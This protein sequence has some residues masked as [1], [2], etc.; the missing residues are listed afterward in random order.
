MLDQR[1]QTLL[2]TLIERYIADGHPVGSRALSKYSNLELSP[3]TIR[4]V[5]SDLEEMG[6]I[7]SP[8][9][10]AGRVPTP[11][12]Y[13]FF[14]D[15]L[16]TVQPLGEAA[17]SAV[18][19]RIRRDV[20]QRAIST[21]AQVLSNLSQFAGVVLTPRR[22][23]AF[24]HVEFMRLSDSRVLLII[25]TPDGDV[26]NRILFSDVP[27]TSAQLIEAANHLNAEFAGLGF[28]DILAK[29]RGEVDQIQDD[30]TRLM[31]AAVEAS[32]EALSEDAEDVVI[33]GERNLLENV[34]L[35][36]NM[37]NLR[38]LFALFEQKTSLMR[39][40]DIST[41]AHGV[42]IYIGGD[43]QLVPMDD[44][45]VVTAPYKVDGRVV[46]TLGVIGPTRMAYERVVPIVDITAK[47]LSNAL[48][49]N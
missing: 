35:S 2:K 30:I 34:D 23:L 29:L 25:V 4:N 43:S 26:Q 46:G 42:Q 38:Q 24:K 44:M 17:T 6:F 14:V 7:T 48:S 49:Q 47:L 27:Y 40:L 21:A 15:T 36:S 32:S 20:P 45:T 11:R 3:A 22:A 33:S 10:S 37:D 1:A 12:G 41:R 18:E 19:G 16:M 13:R 39:L 28:E 5:M 8:H 9:T 31:Q